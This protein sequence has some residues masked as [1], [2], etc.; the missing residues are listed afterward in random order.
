MISTYFR[1]LYFTHE[2]QLYW[3]EV[4][5]CS[6]CKIVSITV[7][8]KGHCHGVIIIKGVVLSYYAPSIPEKFQARTTHGRRVLASTQN[9]IRGHT[10]LL[11]GAP[12]K[13]AATRNRACCV[14]GAVAGRWY[15]CYIVQCSIHTNII[16]TE[17][18]HI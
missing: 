13:P 8:Q 3:P 9:L 15:Y 5:S 1:Y 2:N 18:Y 14:Q 17:K 16:W 10:H 6:F 7:S 4:K 11:F 12:L